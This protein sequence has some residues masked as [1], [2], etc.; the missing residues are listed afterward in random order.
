[1]RYNNI[2]SRNVL[3]FFSFLLLL[4]SCKKWEDKAA[5][6]DNRLGSKK[7]CNDPGA[8]NYNWDFPGIPDNTVCFYPTDV[9]NGR[10]LILDSIF[11]TAGYAYARTDSIILNLVPQSRS[12]LQVTALKG[13]CPDK[14]LNFTADRFFKATADSTLLPDSVVM[15][16]QLFCRDKDTISGF[17]SRKQADSNHIRINF[18]V[19]TD[20]GISFH[21]G[22]GTKL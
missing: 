1:M 14:I 10:Y 17:I 6:G 2:M 16:G 3:I 13:W 4:A 9:F 15:T 20:T 8:V 19:L 22:T 5:P 21:V 18:T 7:Y 11:Y 12:K